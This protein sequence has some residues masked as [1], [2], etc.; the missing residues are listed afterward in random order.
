MHEFNWRRRLAL[1][2][3]VLCA[4]SS[5]NGLVA[6]DAVPL[7]IG[8]RRELFVDE[9][10]IDK[11]DGV[12]LRLHPPTPREIV[13]RLRRPLGRERLRLPHDLSRRRHRP[14][15][16]HRGRPDQRGRHRSWPRGRSTPATPRARTAS[17]GSSPSWGCSSSTARRRTTSS[18]RD[19]GS[20][21][22]RRS[23]IRTPTAGRTSATRRWPL[24][25]G[26][27]LAYKSA[28]GIH[29]SP[30]GGQAD[31]HQG[32]VRHAEQRLL[33]PAAQAL[34]VLHPRLPRRH[35]RHPRVDLDRLSHLDRAASCS[36]FVDCARRA[37]LHEPG[38]AVLPRPAP[39][40]RLPDALRRTQVVAVAMQALPDPE[41]RRAADEVSSALRHGRDRRPVHDQPRRPHVPPLGRG[42]S[43]SRPA[44]AKTT[45]STAT[46]TRTWACSRPPADDPTAPPE[47]SFYVVEDH[48]KRPD[49]AAPLHAADRRLRRAARPAQGRRVRHQAARLQRQ[50]A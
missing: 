44:S 24:G 33:G 32:G 9:F 7:D 35:P 11:R 26:G 25:P 43:P 14:H 31:H 34:L 15:V 49:T 6:A 12:E 18:G 50:D 17:T 13:I 38:A 16:L 21:T 22:S 29:W 39:V 2:V 45:G 36:T 1:F 3:F 23:R 5:R 27:L 37:A 28:D 19:R 48:W 10:L 4:A 42:V 47:L 20:T 46:A 30:L 40:R 8:N 41:H